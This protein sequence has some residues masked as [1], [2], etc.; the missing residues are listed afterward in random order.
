MMQQGRIAGRLIKGVA[1]GE[2]MGVDDIGRYLSPEQRRMLVTRLTDDVT[3]RSAG[4]VA[5]AR[6]EAAQLLAQA[7]A[8]ADAIRA[9][10]YQEGLAAGYEE[11][12]TAARRE[13]ED[14]VAFLKRAAEGAEAARTALLEG[15]EEQAVELALEAARAIVGAAAQ[16]HAALAAHVVREGLRLAGGRA[17]RVRV[18][19]DD[20]APVAA[21]VR[22][23]GRDL[24]I[25]P[26]G[27][28]EVGGCI[29]DLAGG[30]IDL[31]LGVQLDTV[32]RA[33]TDAA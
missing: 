24:A 20:A 11:G 21:V 27:L 22:T 32:T 26:D 12:E 29:V 3:A 16:E 28:I 25:V 14:V 19:P 8:E 4:V 18:H 17:L 10:A 2:A 6:A 7:Q 30:T 15:A 31:R 23:L 1:A 9:R 33:L 13:M 5:E